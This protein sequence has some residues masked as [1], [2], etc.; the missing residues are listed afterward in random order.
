M[1]LLKQKLDENAAILSQSEFN[2][3]TRASALVSSLAIVIL[4]KTYKPD[5]PREHILTLL[6]CLSLEA[7]LTE[8]KCTLYEVVL[9]EFSEG[10]RK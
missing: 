9:E 4:V 10:L 7:D 8:K 5:L 3:K 2:F 6:V 1:D